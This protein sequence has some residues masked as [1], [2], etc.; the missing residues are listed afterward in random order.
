MTIDASALFNELAEQFV[1]LRMERHEKGAIKYGEFTFLAN[2]VIRMM[3]EELADLANYAEY[4]AAKLLI[5]QA[6]LEKDQRLLDMAHDGGIT[7]GVQA[8]KGTGEGWRK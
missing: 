2:D 3:L 6:V 4:Q 8:F 1:E 7:I 5:L